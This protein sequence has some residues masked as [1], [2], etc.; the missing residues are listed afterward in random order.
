MYPINNRDLWYVK[1]VNVF[2]SFAHPEMIQ[3]RRPIKNSK[4]VTEKPNHLNFF[5]EYWIRPIQLYL[6]QVSNE[7]STQQM[8][9]IHFLW[10]DGIIVT[11]IMVVTK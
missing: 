9:N 11:K 3:R 4:K 5:S 7:L 10:M 2:K 8:D 1:L 6:N